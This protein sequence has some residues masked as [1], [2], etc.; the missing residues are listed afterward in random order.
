MNELH[1]RL[2]RPSRRHSSLTAGCYLL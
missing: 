2:R 1:R